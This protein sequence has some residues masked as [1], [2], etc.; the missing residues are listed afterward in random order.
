MAL[1]VVGAALAADRVHEVIVVTSDPHI[2][3]AVRQLKAT[4]VADGG[5]GLNPALQA[6]PVT[7]PRVY[8]LADL[9]AL[10][11]V[12]LDLTLALAEQHDTSFV[13][14]AAG[15]GTSALFATSGVDIFFGPDS[16]R[17]HADAGY[18]ALAPV[19]VGITLD[20]DSLSDLIACAGLGCGPRTTHVINDLASTGILRT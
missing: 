5:A 14:D 15:T 3:W 12:D 2:S 13:V 10:K 19:P 4:V 1:D 16:A 11:P 18:T 7:G 20:V 9:A 8:L 17:L 6:A